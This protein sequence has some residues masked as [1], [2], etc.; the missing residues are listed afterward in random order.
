M[1][2]ALLWVVPLALSHAELRERARP[3]FALDLFVLA[4][5]M[6]FLLHEILEHSPLRPPV[7]LALLP[8]AAA[9]AWLVTISI[10]PLVVSPQ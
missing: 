4:W 3:T 2:D 7:P 9:T 6:V 10:R 5:P 1:L 8:M